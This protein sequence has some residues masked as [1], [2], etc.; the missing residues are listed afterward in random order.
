MPNVTQIGNS[1]FNGCD[2]LERISAPKL[3][4]VGDFSFGK[5]ANLSV[6]DAPKLVEV[7]KNAFAE[8][9]LIENDE[10][11]IALINGILVYYDAYGETTSINDAKIIAN[12]LFE[13]DEA[14]DEFSFTNVETIGANAF[15][16]S[17]L[18]R[19]EI[20]H[21]KHIKANAFKNTHIKFETS[22]FPQQFTKSDFEKIL[23]GEEWNES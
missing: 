13:G 11:G 20:P 1:A 12:G 5:T 14:I 21:V 7:G 17:S 16:D 18:T 4:E 6:F 19:I 9:K 10:S 8:S 22:V 3:I 2:N 15:L 23:N